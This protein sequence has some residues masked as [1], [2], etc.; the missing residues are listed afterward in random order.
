VKLTHLLLV[1]AIIFPLGCKNASP[2]DLLNDKIGTNCT[3]EFRR[4]DAL[5]SAAPLP[6]SPQTRSINGAD[7]A[8]S[9]K[10]TAVDSNWIV[11]D[12][13]TWV[14]RSSILLIQF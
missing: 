8:I 3:V 5:G 2:T 13:K 4:G 11:L 6:V 14:P 9:G 1:A 7:V 10:L 12:E